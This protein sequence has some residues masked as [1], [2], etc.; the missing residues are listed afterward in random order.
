MTQ[1]RTVLFLQG[2]ASPFFSRVADAV[3]ARGARAL[4]IN[5]SLGDRIFWRRPG[6][7]WFRG[8]FA[9]WDAFVRRVLRE[10]R[11]T[12]VVLLGESRAYHTVA[13]D[14]AFAMGVRVHVVEHGYL[15][16]GWLT[17]EPDG[18]T[19]F[20]RFPREAAGVVKLAEG[21]P[22]LPT[23]RAYAESFLRY[24]LFDLAYNLPNAILGPVVHPR[25]RRHAI[26]HPF[27]EYA[28]WLWKFWKAGATQ[29]AASAALARLEGRGY[30]LFPLQL[31]TDYQIRV[32]APGGDLHRLIRATV[33]SFARHAPADTLLVFKVHPIDNGLTNWHRHIGNMAAKAGVGDRIA[34]VDGGRLD[35]ML[36]GARGVVTVNS[37][38]GTAALAA[39]IP[40]I[41]LGNAIYDIDGLTHAGPLDSFWTGAS[42]PDPDL[43]QAFFRAL[44]G[45]IQLRGSFV[46]ADGITDGAE[47]VAGRVLRDDDALPLA[48]RRPRRPIQ[49][50][51]A[52]EFSEETP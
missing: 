15:R 38:V 52:T 43:T 25:Y 16:P 4:R 36:A 10:E 28:G 14:A 51:R 40:L 27:V 39:G 22:E 18:M 35:A 48:D 8:A 41:A 2:P 24:A 17:V 11:V 3:E 34:V 12:D 49:F 5:F 20:S 32:H 42:P 21:S 44:V 26:H 7:R 30:Y 50:R 13:I 47:A 19:S 45:T 9:E 23:G 37:T 29:R 31:P 1:S 6:A 46:A 33:R